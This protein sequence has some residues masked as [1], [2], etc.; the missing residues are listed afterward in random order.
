MGPVPGLKVT[1]EPFKVHGREVRSDTFS[2]PPL[3]LRCTG[4]ARLAELV[5]EVF[6]TN[7]PENEDGERDVFYKQENPF[8][9]LYCMSFLHQRGLEHRQRHGANLFQTPA[10]EH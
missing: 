4:T 8:L 5:F 3:P 10:A 1:P 2:Q 7:P 6:S 9:N